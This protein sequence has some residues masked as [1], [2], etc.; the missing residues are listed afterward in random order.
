MNIIK[1][2]FEQGSAEWLNVRAGKLTAS[3]INKILT[4]AKLEFSKQSDDLA[5]K[6][7]AERIIGAPIENISTWQMNAGHAIEDNAKDVYSENYNKIIDSG[8]IWNEDLQI[9]CS[10]DG[11]IGDDG[12]C[13]VKSNSTAP[14]VHFNCVLKNE[15]PDTFKLQVQTCLLVTGRKWWDFISAVEGMKL[16]VKR[17][18]PDLE[19]HKKIIT[20]SKMFNERVEYLVSEYQTLTANLPLLEKIET[21]DMGIL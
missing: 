15:M 18:Y 2:N 14:Q 13:E 5:M 9:G 10:P 4:P 12:G 3:E 6:I 20:A 8:F 7:A 16:F 1:Y 17:I 21:V 11:L 19:V